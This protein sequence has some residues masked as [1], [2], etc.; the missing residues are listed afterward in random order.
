MVS[1]LSV[2]VD[3]EIDWFGRDNSGVEE[4]EEN[5]RFNSRVMRVRELVV[6]NFLDVVIDG[7]EYFVFGVSKGCIE[8]FIIIYRGIWGVEE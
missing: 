8:F 5:E 6:Y 4:V 7:V 2:R 3:I 1:F